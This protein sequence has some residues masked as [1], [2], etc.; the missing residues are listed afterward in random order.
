MLR[1]LLLLSEQL[2]FQA[3]IFSNRIAKMFILPNSDSKLLDF[4]I[5]DCS[6]LFFQIPGLPGGLEFA[7]E[8]LNCQFKSI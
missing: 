4:E 2:F 8:P 7:K 5:L 1:E 3:A 6:N